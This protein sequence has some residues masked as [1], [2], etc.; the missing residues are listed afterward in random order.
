MLISILIGAAALVAV[1]LC[2]SL[3]LFAYLTGRVRRATALRVSAL[4]VVLGAS[5]T[6]NGLIGSAAFGPMSIPFGVFLMVAAGIAGLLVYQAPKS[7]TS[8]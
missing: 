3:F 1:C 5:V 4:G 7:D 6:A 8:R 2:F